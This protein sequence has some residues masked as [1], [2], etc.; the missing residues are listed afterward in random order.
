[1][2]ENRIGQKCKRID[3]NPKLTPNPNPNQP[4]SCV[5]K[6]IDDL[7]ATSSGEVNDV[8]E[9]TRGSCRQVVS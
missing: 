1:M 6:P 7:S 8:A 4:W 2:S 5:I 9:S 3:P